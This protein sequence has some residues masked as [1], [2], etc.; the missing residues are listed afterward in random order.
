LSTLKQEVIRDNVIIDASF[1]VGTEAV[2][3]LVSVVNRKWKEYRGEEG[4][5]SQLSID[6]RNCAGAGPVNEGCGAEYVQ[7]GQVP[8]RGVD[9]VRD[10][11]R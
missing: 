7:K 6:V 2:T 9:A 11:V 3:H 8:P 1:G 5:V 10:K 4:E